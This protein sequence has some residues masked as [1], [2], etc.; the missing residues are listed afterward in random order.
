[1]QQNKTKK[2]I[3]FDIGAESGRCVVGILEKNR[4]T[5]KEVHRFLTPSIF[6]AGSYQ[7]DIMAIYRELIT[8]LS[9]AKDQFGNRFDGV[10]VDTWG[11][12]YV[13]LDADN[14]LLGNPY[15][16]RDS[17][18]DGILEKAFKKVDRKEIYKKTGIQFIQF[19]TLFQLFAE[20]GHKL[21]LI[22]QA[23]KI[24]MIPD[25]LLFL[26]CG[27]KKAEYSIV[28]TSN[29]A[30]P[31]QRDWSWDL[32]SS[33]D[34]PKKIFPDVI[35]PGKLLGNLLPE[36]AKKTGIAENTPVIAG[37]SHDTA[38]AVA[39]VPALE[40]NW[41][42]L[43]SGTWSLMGVE[44]PGPL[45]NDYALEYN[46]TN[47]GGVGKTI[48]FLKNIIG[49]WPVQ[50]CR[51]YWLENGKTFNYQK[52]AEL[53]LENG[54]ARSWINLDNPRFLKP[55]E[56]P[57]KII[58]FLS[59][60]NQQFRENEG[61]IIR[62]VLESLAFKYRTTIGELEK[63]TGK[64]IDRLYAVGGGI[65]NEVLMQLTA[66]ALAREVVAG[67]IEGTVVG[68]IGIQAIATGTI[69]DIRELRKI[70]TGSFELTTYY[71]ENPEYFDNNEK[72]Y[73]QIAGLK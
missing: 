39:A 42:Y 65:Q 50:E 32:I 69:R 72:L 27:K 49:L 2:Y 73:K 51:R 43:S 20:Q 44:L 35:E 7:W 31:H 10:S 62:S 15:H 9:L 52:L 56:M 33:F 3:G 28:S 58:S 18:T 63:V 19:N 70:V 40:K 4:I 25:Y 61:W 26:L 48:R 57:A 47:E 24:L 41:A 14:R 6:S 36:L 64:K 38:A 71:P 11:V 59:E 13:L 22:K 1:M 68:N 45:I 8:G 55:G 34:L 16:Y 66:D 37:A 67:P 21:N 54:P 5:L 53:A 17:R 12:D 46:F 23:D 29:L 60:T 30:D